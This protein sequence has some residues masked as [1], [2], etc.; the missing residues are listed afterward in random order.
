MK[1]FFSLNLLFLNLKI[2]KLKALLSFG[3]IF[4][5]FIY[6]I[7]ITI[8]KYDLKFYLNLMNIKIKIN[9]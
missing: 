6:F 7:I 4:Y 5:F 8:K 2:K 9:F 1:I 3:N